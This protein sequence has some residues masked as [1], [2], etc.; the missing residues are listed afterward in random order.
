MSQISIMLLNK[1]LS[2]SKSENWD[3]TL[4]DK[5]KAKTYNWQHITKRFQ[6][7][8]VVQKYYENV[9]KHTWKEKMLGNCRWKSTNFWVVA[10]QKKRKTLK[11]E[12]FQR[13]YSET[14]NCFLMDKVQLFQ[15]F[16][17]TTKRQFTCNYFIP[18]IF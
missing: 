5:F 1:T 4:C 9:K 13:T 11:L 15:G 18:T 16:R 12:K 17:D 14:Q 6:K 2:D 3:T 10:F 7:F 8:N